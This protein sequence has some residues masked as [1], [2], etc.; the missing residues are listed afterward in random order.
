MKKEHDPLEIISTKPFDIDSFEL[1]ICRD[2]NQIQSDRQIWFVWINVYFLT[3][4]NFRPFKHDSPYW[5][6]FQWGRNELVLFYSSKH[7]HIYIA[8]H[9]YI[10]TFIESIHTYIH[11]Y[12]HTGRHGYSITYWQTYFICKDVYIA[13]INTFI[14]YLQLYASTIHNET[15]M[16]IFQKLYLYEKHVQIYFLKIW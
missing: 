16:T 14:F 2:S 12:R 1:V 6:P 13:N 11:T 3:N 7:S 15:L 5:L 10:H 8:I 4:I 9:S